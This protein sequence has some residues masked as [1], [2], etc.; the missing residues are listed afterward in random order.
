M[1]TIPNGVFAT[2]TI[3]NF[4]MRDRFWF[5]PVLN[6]RY[7]T[8]PDQI[9]YLL[10]R[11][12][13]LLYSHPSVDPD[14]ARVRFAGFGVDAL[15][16]EISAYINA[17]DNNEFME[18]REDLMLRIMDI[19]TESGTGFAFRSQTLY[20]A[21]DIGLS[22]EKRR[23]AEERVREWKE[24]DALELPSFKPE[25][26]A[27]LRNTIQWPPEGSTAA[28]KKAAAQNG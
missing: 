28:A 27:E 19:V 21:K 1:V 9:R 25:R 26:I 4:A 11:V 14:P 20:M 23:A 24:K 15:N 8:T 13:E 6:L 5:H 10:V 7:E 18:V 17:E 12:R 22:E 16:I 3:E 2:M